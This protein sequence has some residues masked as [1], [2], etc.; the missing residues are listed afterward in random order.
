M[1]SL[2]RNASKPGEDLRMEECVMLEINSNI[3]C[4]RPENAS[5]PGEDLCL[6]V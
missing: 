6:E 3:E 4:Y 2:L 5:K 1:L